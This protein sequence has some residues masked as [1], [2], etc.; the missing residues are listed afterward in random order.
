MEKIILT[1]RSM[2]SVHSVN[3]YYY[4]ER[5]DLKNIGG[6]HEFNSYTISIGRIIT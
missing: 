6:T 1:W 5:L 4:F 2:K 3:C